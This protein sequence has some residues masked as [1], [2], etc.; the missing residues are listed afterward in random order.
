MTNVSQF[1]ALLSLLWFMLDPSPPR[2]SVICPP[3]G[4]LYFKRLIICSRTLP[5]PRLS[6]IFDFNA[7]AGSHGALS[8]SQ[9]FTRLS[10]FSFGVSA[11]LLRQHL[12]PLR[13]LRSHHPHGRA[14]P[15]SHALSFIDEVFNQGPPGGL[16]YSN[17]RRITLIPHQ[18]LIII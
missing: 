12:Q 9:A 14:L 10:L 3:S 11:R 15:S 4:F 18:R 16:C 7:S 1:P 17:A 8:V 5:P 2:S 6:S 13:M